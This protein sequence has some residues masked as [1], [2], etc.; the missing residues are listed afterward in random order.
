MGNYISQFNGNEIDEAIS[1]VNNLESSV[2]V[3]NTKTEYATINSAGVVQ[4]DDVLSDSNLKVPTSDVFHK[5]VSFSNHN[6]DT[7]Y[8]NREDIP[9][10][11]RNENNNM[12]I[13]GWNYITTA[14]T[15]PIP[16]SA[17]EVL[18]ININID[19][20]TQPF[21]PCRSIIFEFKISNYQNLIDYD[22]GGTSLLSIKFYDLDDNEFIGSLNYATDS[23]TTYLK[24]NSSHFSSVTFNEPTTIKKITITTNVSNLNGTLTNYFFVSTIRDFVSS[25]IK[26]SAGDSEAIKTSIVTVGLKDKTRTN[27]SYLYTGISP[28]LPN[29]A[30]NEFIYYGSDRLK[31]LAQSSSFLYIGDGKSSFEKVSNT[32][33]IG[34]HSMIET[35]NV[36]AATITINWGLSSIERISYSTIYGNVIAY[37]NV[38]GIIEYSTLIG[39]NISNA[40]PNTTIKQ[41]SIMQSVAVGNVI[42]TNNNKKLYQSVVVGNYIG[43]RSLYTCD[44]NILIGVSIF[45]T[46][47]ELD[48]NSTVVNNW[49]NTIVG[50]YINSGSLGATHLE[51]NTL[52][53]H[54]AAQGFAST[55]LTKVTAIGGITSPT[56]SKNTQNTQSVYIGYNAK[57]KQNTSNTSTSN[58]IVIGA[59]ASG[60]GSNTIT[61]GNS[62]ITHLYCKATAITAPSDVRLKEEIEPADIFTC[63]NAVLSLPVSRYKY[64]DFVGEY[65]DKHVTGFL[66]DDVEKVFPKSVNETDR[67]FPVIE[68]GQQIFIINEYGEKIEKTFLIEKVKHI[69]MQECTPTL[70][71]AVQALYKEISDIKSILKE[72]ILNNE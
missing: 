68:N 2:N 43:N 41:V 56:A 26:I 34:I 1:K 55:D 71:G 18:T 12:T 36:K 32:I 58:E 51:H 37:H 33:S 38:P 27:N 65:Y 45:Q 30:L 25:P 61:L 39:N 3:L 16:T 44:N 54:Y 17:N 52:I 70:W 13:T 59:S 23:G 28:P 19:N 63:L 6:F 53:G 69:T 42:F 46:A 49:Y 67:Y 9:R 7:E 14:D 10:E 20:L 22:N 35:R 57:P 5:G 48:T 64:K 29:A 62:S 60:N 11:F 66:A 50:N 72:K 24:H 4:L 8:L 40:I 47:K 31:K 21:F 15:I